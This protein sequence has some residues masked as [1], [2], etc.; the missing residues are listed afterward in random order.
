MKPDKDLFSVQLVH[1]QGLHLVCK[2][3]PKPHLHNI[4]DAEVAMPQGWGLP[5]CGKGKF[6]M[7]CQA[8]NASHRSPV[9]LSR[10]AYVISIDAQSAYGDK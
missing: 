8:A 10:T 7:P 2:L 3:G 1:L 4:S 6:N 9:R 5:G